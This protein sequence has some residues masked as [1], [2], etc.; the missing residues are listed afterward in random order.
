VRKF[1]H[2][3]A[4]YLYKQKTLT[5]TG[6]GSFTVEPS[7]VAPADTDKQPH[8]PSEGIEFLH[9]KAAKTPEELILY[10]LAQTGRIKP[11]LEA[12]F[13]NYITEMQQ[14]LNLGK[15]FVINGIGTLQK[16]KSGAIEFKHGATVTEKINT[17]YGM[18]NLASEEPPLLHNSAKLQN[19]IKKKNIVITVIS[20]IGIVVAGSLGWLIFQHLQKSATPV[21]D[22]STP[23]VVPTAISSDTTGAKP[24]TTTA[25]PVQDS[26]VINQATDT[27]RYRVIFEITANRQLA[28]NRLNTLKA[29]GDKV[30]IDSF[31]KAEDPW[32]RLFYY[33]RA[34]AADTTAVKKDAA[35]YYKRSIWL[36]K[37][38]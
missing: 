30:N 36:E 13:E 18:A 21:T 29:R 19:S 12:D 20:I 24:N 8:F 10:L 14:W 38:Q 22:L 2:L 6:V 37:V 5:I 31:Y 25:P 9:H 35:T 11:L 17:T 28:F 16:I 1:D 23:I 34:V 33:K 7:F 3:L 32:Y 26:G 27:L 4:G 15:P